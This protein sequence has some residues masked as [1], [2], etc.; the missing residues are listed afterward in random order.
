M[1]KGLLPPQAKRNK[2]QASY[3]E[4]FMEHIESHLN[5]TEAHIV[6]FIPVM[7]MHAASEAIGVAWYKD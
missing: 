7:G 3:G 2:G 1:Q 4:D 5:C 6:E